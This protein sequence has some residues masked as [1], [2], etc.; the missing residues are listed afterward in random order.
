MDARNNTQR[1]RPRVLLKAPTLAEMEEMNTSEVRAHGFLGRAQGGGRGARRWLKQ[2]P[3]AT[4]SH[5]TERAGMCV[6][7]H[8]GAGKLN[9]PVADVKSQC[10]SVGLP[11]MSSLPS[12]P[13]KTRGG[14][15]LGGLHLI[16]DQS[17]PR[18]P[19]GLRE[20]LV[21]QGPC[22]PLSRG[23]S[24]WAVS[25]GWPH[26]LSGPSSSPCQSRDRQEVLVGSGQG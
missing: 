1:P 13:K 18:L 3:W 23:Q 26:G 4:S 12:E 19:I 9:S 25:R 24:G 14:S 21:F 7:H 2:W 15:N 22:F 20:G 16:P 5:R 11:S 8:L 17:S 6:L 10:A